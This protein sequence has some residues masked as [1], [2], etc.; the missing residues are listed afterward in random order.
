VRSGDDPHVVAR[1]APVAGSIKLDRIAEVAA[2]LFAAGDH[3]AMATF[4]GV[5][6]TE[7]L[8]IVV[9]SASARDLL[10][11]IPLVEW[12]DSFGHVIAQVP[13]ATIDALLR[14]V[15][16][17]GLWEAG[18]LLIEQLDPAALELALERA[19]DL[20]QESFAAFRRAADDG[21]L[22]PVAGDLVARADAL[23]GS[24]P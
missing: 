12:T 20:P 14:E 2:A 22:S 18:C 23:R 16:D 9:Q 19:R 6:P 5:V 7:G 21:L 8:L 1:L 15:A 10:A 3:A 11:I 4:A 17:A 24:M 13:V